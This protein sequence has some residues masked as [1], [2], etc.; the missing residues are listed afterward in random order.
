MNS[1]WTKPLTVRK[2]GQIVH[3]KP[4]LAF[5]TSHSSICELSAH[6]KDVTHVSSLYAVCSTSG[7]QQVDAMPNAAQASFTRT[8]QVPC[9]ADESVPPS[10]P[11]ARRALTFSNESLVANEHLPTNSSPLVG[12]HCSISTGVISPIVYIAIASQR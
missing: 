3:T 8:H 2:T 9:D 12:G 7:H 1:A 6:L 5:G 11:L 10:R 4:L